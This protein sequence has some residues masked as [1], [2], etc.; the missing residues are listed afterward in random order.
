MSQQI[1][2][3]QPPN[4]FD[5]VLTEWLTRFLNEINTALQVVEDYAPLYQMPPKV[6]VGMVRYFGAPV[7]PDI[8]AEGLWIYKGTG[9]TQAA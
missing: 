8:T 1:P 9:W 6:S 7:L 5:P 4:G 3:I 2:Q